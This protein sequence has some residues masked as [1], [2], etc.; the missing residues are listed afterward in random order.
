M[1]VVISFYGSDHK[2]GTSMIAQCF[3]E[4]TAS[5]YKDTDVLLVHTESGDGEA[6]SPC[7]NESLETIRP[8]LAEKLIDCSSLMEK[9]RYKDN[10]FI[11]G[12][13]A[14]PGTSSQYHPDMAQ[15][16]LASLASQFDYV[17]CDTGSEIEQ[18][19]ALGTLF[20]SDYIF[21]VTTQDEYSIR[22]YEWVSPLFQKLGIKPSGMIV[23]KYTK[24]EVNDTEIIA[25]RSGIEANA[26]LLIR[27]AKNGKKAEQESK[28]LL[29]YKDNRFSRDFINAAESILTRCNQ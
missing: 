28:S 4:Y 8:Y 7:V 9:S 22:R 23:N 26:L 13:V 2:C 27:N 5:K 20:C 12:G 6:Y 14:K 19:M 29:M 11:I 3:A 15:Y 24:D 10:L 25:M 1:G 21:V 16:L 18:V 17:I